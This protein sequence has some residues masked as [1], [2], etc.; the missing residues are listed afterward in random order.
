MTWWR[1]LASGSLVVVS[2]CGNGESG[3]ALPKRADV[4]VVA[5]SG[6][7]L[8]FDQA[9][10]TARAGDITIAYKN[11]DAIAHTMILEQPDGQRV[12]GFMR[13]VLGAHRSTSGSVTIAPGDYKI[14]CDIHL[15]T[16]VADLTITP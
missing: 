9:S 14:V 15:P 11:D 16:M 5:P 10:Y 3:S 2:A 4:L 12:R 13:I 7:G 6:R 1:L 8:V